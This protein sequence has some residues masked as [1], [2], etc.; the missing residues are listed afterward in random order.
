MLKLN[1]STDAKNKAVDII[2]VGVE[3]VLHVLCI[4]CDGKIIIEHKA[5]INFGHLS[6]IKVIFAVQI[7]IA[8]TDVVIL[9]P[10]PLAGYIQTAGKQRIIVNQRPVILPAE[11]NPGTEDVTELLIK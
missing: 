8:D 3:F 10:I 9:T 11:A 2:L 4:R 7:G 5:P 6:I 1:H